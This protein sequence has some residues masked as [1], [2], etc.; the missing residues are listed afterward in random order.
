MTRQD[1]IEQL[2]TGIYNITFTKVNG[3]ERTM[4]C[5]LLESMLPPARAEEPITQKKV[6]ELNEKVVAVW[7]V[8]KKS[9]RSFRIDNVTKIE[10]WTHTSD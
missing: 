2:K 1:L 9:F 8:D 4:S 3:E 10:P 6:R 5:T 7:C